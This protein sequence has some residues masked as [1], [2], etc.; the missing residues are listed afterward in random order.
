MR[1]NK[2]IKIYLIERQN[3]RYLIINVSH[4]KTKGTSTVWRREHSFVQYSLC[5]ITK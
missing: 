5:G 1:E 2:G 3:N 4:L